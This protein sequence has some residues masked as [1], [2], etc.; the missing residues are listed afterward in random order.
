MIEIIDFSHNEKGHNSL[1]NKKHSHNNCYEIL[2]AYSGNGAVVVKNKLYHLKKNTIYFINGIE[3]H[4]FVPKNDTPYIRSKIIIKSTY[5]DTISSIANCRD[6]INDLFFEDG[7][8]CIEFDEN[9][10][11]IIN[12]EFLKIKNSIDA[13]DVYANIN[14][15]LSLFKILTLSHS[16]KNSKMPTIKNN[17]SEVLTYI[18]ENIHQKINLD[19]LC[20][21]IH[22]NKY[23][24]CHLFKKETN[25]TINEYIVLQR[26]A[27]AKKML[28]YTDEPLSNIALG[29]GFGSFSYFSKL[30]KERENITPRT[31]RQKYKTNKIEVNIDDVTPK[32]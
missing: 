21:Y 30:F 12:A 11:M 5:I 24:L 2:F 9:Q 32:S 13:K 18:N 14:I 23:Y 22:C 7:G 28:L 10:S 20:A 29:C 6:I 19:E 31:F 8:S 26:L 17:I 27:I 1:N 16:N 15:T 25:M 4:C 3:T